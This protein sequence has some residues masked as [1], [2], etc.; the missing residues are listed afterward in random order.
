M[1][2]FIANVD[3]KITYY[4]SD[5]VRRY[6]EPKI[7]YAEDESEATSKIENYYSKQTSKYSEYYSCSIDSISEA[8]M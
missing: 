3:V 8:I 2:L 4:D 6:T 7:V 1:K 5:K